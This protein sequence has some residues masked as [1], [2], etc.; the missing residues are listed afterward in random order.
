MQ[1]LYYQIKPVVFA[2]HIGQLCTFLYAVDAVFKHASDVNRLPDIVNK[3]EFCSAQAK[4][5]PFL[6]KILFTETKKI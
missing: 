4:K 6:E 5:S 3:K 1:H 2:K